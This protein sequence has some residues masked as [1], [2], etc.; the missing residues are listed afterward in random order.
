MTFAG[1]MV[2]A[3]LLGVGQAKDTPFPD[4]V[5]LDSGVSGHIHPALC[6][7]P[8]GTLVATWCRSEYKPHLISRSTDG[9]ATWSKPIPFP[10]TTDTQVY[11]GSLTTLA[12]G[13]LVHT[14]NVWFSLD[15][16]TKSRFVAYSISSDD[17]QTWAPPIALDKAADPKIHSVLRH[18]VLEL[19]PRAW[20]V[21]LADRTVVYDPVAKTSSPFG[22][23]AHGL[24]PLVRTPKGTL[25]S[26]KGL[27]STDSGKTWTKV[28]PFPDVSSQGWRHEMTVL[29]NGWLLAS[30][31]VGPGVGGEKIRFVVSRDDGQTWD[32]KRP[33]EFY[34][35]SRAIGGRACPK[36]VQLDDATLG[37]IFYDISPMQP[38]GPGVF[39]RKTPMS[40]LAP[41]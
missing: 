15:A 19:G 29:K 40:R 34:D 24:V 37:T 13:R 25:V 38:V 3:T 23:T 22:E 11:P 30:E 5:R 21:P 14:W 17:G 33:I 12:D 20:A 8:K 16:K 31:I 6:V 2:A 28:T 1:W 7:T 35:P 18:P 26:G 4:I 32:M 36:T 27:R 39:F 9:G 10:H 41:E